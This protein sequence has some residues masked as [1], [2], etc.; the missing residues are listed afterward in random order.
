MPIYIGNQK[1]NPS[2]IEKVYVG[3]QLVYQNVP[4]LVSISTSGQTT[5][6]KTYDTFSYNGTCTA[7]YS[8]GTTAIVTPAV[9]SPT[10]S[11]AGTKAVTLTYTEN[12]ITVTTSYNITVSKAWRIIYN[13]SSGKMVVKL[14]TGKTFTKGG[15]PANISSHTEQIRINYTTTCDSGALV[16]T[17]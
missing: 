5:S 10:M 2:G 17:T 6:Y 1:I 14:N 16:I 9:S 8:N 12:G 13:N 7:T 3:T 15:V 4:V 11:S